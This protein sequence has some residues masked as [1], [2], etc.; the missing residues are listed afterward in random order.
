MELFGHNTIGKSLE[1]NRF[2]RK[3]VLAGATS[4]W[5]Q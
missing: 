3:H 4:S 2:R 5:V 1:I